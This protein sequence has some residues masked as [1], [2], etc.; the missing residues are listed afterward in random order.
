MKHSAP[1]AEIHPMKAEINL[2]ETKIELK[3][4]IS[5]FICIKLQIITKRITLVGTETAAI[6]LESATAT[7]RC[8]CLWRVLF[9]N[10]LFNANRALS[11]KTWGIQNLQLR[12]N[13]NSTIN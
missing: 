1:A 13:V 4:E 3:S 7:G 5:L 9:E 2:M 8:I 11:Q 12:L 10:V 6:K